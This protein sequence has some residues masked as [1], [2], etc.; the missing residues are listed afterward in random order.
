MLVYLFTDVAADTADL[1]TLLPPAVERSFNSISIDGDTSTNDTVL[2]LAS[3]ASEVK[4]TDASRESFASALKLVCNDLAHAIVD[5]GEGVT[6]VVTLEISGCRSE[7]EAKTI[8]RSIAH[9]PL[10]KTAWSSADPNWGRL[11]AA[12]GYSGVEFNPALV[13]VHI[14][15]VP[16]YENG[17]RSPSFDEAR[18]HCTMQQREYTISMN[19]AQGEAGCRFLTCDLT[20]EYVRINADYST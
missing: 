13:T 15:D 8:A 5:D 1:R 10:C 14:G 9:S 19:F 18:A 2:L 16:V 11:M 7:A 3:G 12:A 6:H 20:E 4:L 17:M